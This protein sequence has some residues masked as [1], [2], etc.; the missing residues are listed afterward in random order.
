MRSRAVLSVVSL[1]LAGVSV[2]YP[3]SAASCRITFR[4]ESWRFG[5]FTKPDGTSTNDV[6]LVDV[7]GDGHLDV[8]VSEGTATFE[9]RQ[10]HLLMNDGHGRFRD[11]TT[12]RLPA[13]SINSGKVAWGD[14]DGT[15]RLSALV[16]GSGDR[17]GQ[18]LLNDGHGYFRDAT[19]RL[20]AEPQ[21][22]S[23]NVTLVDIDGN[24]T[25]DALV[26]NENPFD[27][28]DDHG[29][30]NWLW[31]NDGHGRFTDETATRLPQRLDQTTAVRAGRFT[32]H[33]LPDL[34]V[35]NR[36]QKRVLVNDGHGR[37]TDETAERFPVTTDPSRDGALHDFRGA[38]VL[39]LL[40]SNSQNAPMTYYRN[41]GRGHFTAVPVGI[42][43][44]KDEVDSAIALGDLNRDGHIDVFQ[45]NAGPR[46]NGSHTFQGGPSRFFAGDGHGHFADRTADHFPPMPDDPSISVALGDIN[47]DGVQDVLLGNGSDDTITGEVP[48]RL[49]MSHRTRR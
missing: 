4:D 24:R 6:S 1:V 32:G 37:F 12:R 20:P 28:S 44:L 33:R 41:D 13:I 17:P 38:G 30:Q 3:A 23:A 26:S 42:P 27:P 8:F 10:S 45:T 39:D 5:A 48:L 25:L 46:S 34:V 9:G 7:D 15:G 47:G 31:I 11:E 36:G 49:Y 40:V 43:Q 29:A 19:D 18:L 35:I 22:V 21:T 16:S 14:I 2:A